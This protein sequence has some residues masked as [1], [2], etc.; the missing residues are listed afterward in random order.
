MIN[1]KILKKHERLLSVIPEGRKNGKRGKDLAKRLGVD[2]RT[3]TKAV[4]CARG[5]GVIICASS[6]DGYYLS[7]NPEDIKAYI[8]IQRASIRT[9]LNSMKSA[10][11]YLEEE[12]L[13]NE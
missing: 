8:A 10:R 2:L 6:E 9:N 11:M 5:D 3:F 12:A 13:Q 1:D 7:K 4:Q